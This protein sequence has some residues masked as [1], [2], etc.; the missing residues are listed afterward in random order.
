MNG[1]VLKA[2]LKNLT[3]LALVAMPMF[4]LL[5]W[6]QALLGRATGATDLGYVIET[7]GVYYLTNLIPVLVGGLVHQAIWLALPGE[8][9]KLVR[10]I[11]ALLLTPLIP[12]AVLISW[13]GPA[14]SLTT[15]AIPMVLALAVYIL[16][17]R[18]PAAPRQLAT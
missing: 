16:L 1:E 17:M 14:G 18:S 4:F 6:I 15:F 8:W 7:G 11:V 5:V 2:A 13:G 3:L 12:I 10:R 9:S